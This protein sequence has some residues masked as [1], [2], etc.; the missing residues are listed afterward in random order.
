[1][2]LISSW[3]RE[4][5]KCPA[6]IIFIIT[7][8]KKQ[9]PETNRRTPWKINMEPEN[10]GLVQMIFLFKMGD[11]LGSSRSSSGVFNPC[12][13][14]F[15][16][17]QTWSPR[18]GWS[19]LATIAVLLVS[20]SLSIGSMVEENDGWWLWAKQLRLLEIQAIMI[21]PLVTVGSFCRFNLFIDMFF[22]SLFRQH[23][24]PNPGNG[25]L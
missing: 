4:F 10:D 9:R 5:T 11:V 19:T 16:S 1:M 14:M 18:P 15:R 23:I 25:M 17:K 22:L 6:R 21:S 7:G 2:D 13:K 8:V 24:I 12:R 3:S 20:T